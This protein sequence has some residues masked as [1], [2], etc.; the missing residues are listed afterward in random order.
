LVY[1]CEILQFI[2]FYLLADPFS[3][4]EGLLKGIYETEED[5]LILVMQDDSTITTELLNHCKT[6]SIEDKRVYF[7]VPFA[8]FNP[9]IIEHG[10]PPGKPKYVN[11]KDHNKFTGHWAHKLKNTFCA[12]HRDISNMVYAANKNLAEIDGQWMY[13]D[14]LKQEYEVVTAVEPNLYK[15]SHNEK[16]APKKHSMNEQARCMKNKA[17]HL[18]SKPALSILY[19]EENLK[20]R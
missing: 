18:A 2:W 11:K 20:N 3:F 7:P 4:H 15:L 6:I 1:F 19:I 14:Y 8:Q 10:M 13:N 16:C 17:L 12:Y 9:E 5:D